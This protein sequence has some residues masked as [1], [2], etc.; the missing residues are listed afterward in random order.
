[1]LIAEAA[2]C[3]N[4]VVV[5]L[6]QLSIVPRVVDIVADV[7]NR[8]NIVQEPRVWTWHVLAHLGAEPCA[9][10]VLHTKY[11]VEELQ[12]RALT[13]TAA[14][15]L[16]PCALAVALVVEDTV[17]EAYGFHVHAAGKE[18]SDL[19]VEDL[20]PAAFVHAFEQLA[21][22]VDAFADI[23]QSLYDGHRVVLRHCF[24]RRQASGDYG[25]CS[26][27]HC[28]GDC[29]EPGLVVGACQGV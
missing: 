12:Q 2:Q 10:I 11:R 4:R 17:R 24:D 23:L 26:C 21:D 16:P 1:M 28:I 19:V 6:S 13:V 22:V 7:C 9:S 25:P 20:R 5:R 15:V 27:L 3:C 14:T 29:V 8:F 18:G